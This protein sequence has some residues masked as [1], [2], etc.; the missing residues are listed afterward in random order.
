MR[1]PVF[2][3]ALTSKKQASLK[4]SSQGVRTL[5]EIA[6]SREEGQKRERFSGVSVVRS[7]ISHQLESRNGM[8]REAGDPS[9]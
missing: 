7:V 9:R 4:G 2:V 8:A 6:G 5:R 3:P 1:V